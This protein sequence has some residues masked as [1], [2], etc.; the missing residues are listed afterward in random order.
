VVGASVTSL[1]KLVKR[2]RLLLRGACKVVVELAM[3]RVME[4]ISIRKAPLSF[5]ELAQKVWYP[6]CLKYL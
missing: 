4:N 6:S 3:S 1:W 2:L 5:V